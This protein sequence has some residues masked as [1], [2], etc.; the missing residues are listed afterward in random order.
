MKAL[1]LIFCACLCTQ[2]VAFCVFSDPQ[3]DHVTV[4]PKQDKMQEKSP[5]DS[6]AVLV[7]AMEKLASNETPESRRALYEALLGS[8]LLVRFPRFQPGSASD[9]RLPRPALKF[10]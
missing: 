9:C 3:G 6:N 2:G 8:M 7:E 10:T 5:F 1:P 4:Q